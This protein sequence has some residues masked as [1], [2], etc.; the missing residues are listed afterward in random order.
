MRVAEFLGELAGVPFPDDG[1][2]RAPR[3]ARRSDA[4][5]RSDA[6]RLRRLPRRRVRRAAGRARPRRSA[7]GR[8]PERA[9]RRRRAPKPRRARRS[10]SSP[11]ARP[12]VKDRS[13]TS[14]HER[15]P[16]RVI[17]LAALTKKAASGSSATC[18]A[19]ASTEARSPDRR[20]RRGQRLLSRG[21]GPRRRRGAR[22]ALPETVL[23]MVE[24]RL[25][26]SPPTR[27]ASSAPRASSARSSGRGGVARARRLEHRPS[28]RSAR[29]LDELD[30][31]RARPPAPRREVPERARA[32]LP[33]R[34]RPRGRV[35]DAHRRR[36][37]R[38]AIASP[39]SGSSRPARPSRSSSPSTSIAAARPTRAAR[40]F[41]ARGAERALGANDFAARPRARR[42]RD[43]AAARAARSSARSASS[44]PRPTTGAASRPSRS[45]PRARRS[46]S[47][48]QAS[49]AFCIA[50]GEAAIGAGRLADRATVVEVAK[51]LR[52]LAGPYAT[53]ARAIAGARVTTQ[54]LVL[55][56]YDLGASSSTRSSATHRARGRSDRARLASPSPAPSAG[57]SPATAAS[58]SR[59]SASR[60]RASSAPAIAG[61]P[62]PSAAT[63]A[64]RTSSSALTPRPRARSSRRSPPPR[65]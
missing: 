31:A 2:R 42:A 23:A 4:H 11:S 61:T 49:A 36:S 63:S 41:H 8:S 13:R 17:R 26:G 16:S 10:S 47:C 3:R 39:A 43:R 14:G 9:A 40:Y 64:T 32:R 46:R 35:R 29:W 51:L 34:P 44:R 50:A 62:A 25:E 27:A 53:A 1:R 19:R 6:P 58:T 48:P 45:P 54:L 18:S 30:G 22:A 65:R 21:A 15:E 12:E 7:L 24:A 38:S 20:A 33:A 57:T 59:S 37:R 5:G 56:R 60:P 55:G 28:A 52:D